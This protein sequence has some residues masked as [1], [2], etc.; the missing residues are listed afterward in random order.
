MPPKRV[1]KRKQDATD[2]GA[3]QLLP[4]YN[5]LRDRIKLEAAARKLASTAVAQKRQM[6][7][8]NFCVEVLHSIGL[9]DIAIGQSERIFISGARK[10]ALGEKDADVV[11]KPEPAAPVV[12]PHLRDVAAS[13][14]AGGTSKSSVGDANLLNR[15]E[16]A[17][18]SSALRAHS[19]VHLERF[20]TSAEVAKVAV[21]L[22][23]GGA[24]SERATA[25]RE[26]SGTGRNGAYGDV[27]MHKV[28]LLAQLKE[29]LLTTLRSRLPPCGRLGDKVLATRYSVGGVNFAHM[30]QSEGGYQAYLLLS[31]PTLDF[32][33]GQLYI[34]DPATAAAASA[35][36]ATRQVEWLASGDLVIF[37]ANSK[38]AAEGRDARN[39][40]H[41]FREVVSGREGAQK[42]HLCVI[43][44]LE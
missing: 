34:I 6:T 28:P 37:A 15:L 12:V 29:A 18:D 2:S 39:W 26:S 44:L 8:M 32:G 22:A 30:D 11:L 1:A 36:D 17:F 41:G 24:S 10:A 3:Q 42:C 14:T 27:N 13:L 23:A 43:G 5:P 19:L 7:A 40:L 16:A 33:G 20:L 38:E 35:E 4:P 25:L 31:R 9:R 21:D